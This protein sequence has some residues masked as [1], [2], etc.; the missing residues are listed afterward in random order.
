MYLNTC[1][2]GYLF[3]QHTFSCKTHHFVNLAEYKAGTQNTTQMTQ[4]PKNVEIIS[5]RHPD[6]LYKKI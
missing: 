5:E 1:I 6:Q 2:I 3:I 4:A